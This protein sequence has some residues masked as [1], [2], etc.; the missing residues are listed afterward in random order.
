[1]AWSQDN[2]DPQDHIWER[3][4]KVAQELRLLPRNL[5]NLEVSWSSQDNEDP[6]DYIWKIYAKDAQE[7]RILG[8]NLMI[9]EMAWLQDNKDP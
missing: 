8:R 1:M 5:R 9:L 7:I 2:K 3:Y 4:A 6:Q